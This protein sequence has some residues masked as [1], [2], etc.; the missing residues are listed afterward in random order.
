MFSL[1]GH[2]YCKAAVNFA[3]RLPFFVM[4][5]KI[6]RHGRS[7]DGQETNRSGEDLIGQNHS[8]HI[9]KARCR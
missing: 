1:V 6:E 7:I 4:Q 8:L 5:N 2:F 3:G 9:S